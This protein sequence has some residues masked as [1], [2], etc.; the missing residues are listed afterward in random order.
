MGTGY[1]QAPNTLQQ[2]QRASPATNLP[3]AHT[4]LRTLQQHGLTQQAAAK[5]DPLKRT[6]LHKAGKSQEACSAQLAFLTWSSGSSEKELAPRSSPSW[7]GAPGC[8]VSGGDK[9]KGEAWNRLQSFCLQTRVIPSS[10]PPAGQRLGHLYRPAVMEGTPSAPEAPG[11][12]GQQP[13]PL[14]PV[15]R[16][17]QSIRFSPETG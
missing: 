12:A 15:V 8:H 9:H 13:H 16:K 17:P 7:P 5:F 4:S 6:A 2:K 10:E 3:G 1:I 11:C 14:S